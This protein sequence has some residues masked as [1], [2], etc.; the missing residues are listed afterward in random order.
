MICNSNT[1]LLLDTN[2]ALMERAETLLYFKSVKLVL[3]DLQFD[4]G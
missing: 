2:L 1:H 3:S 4:R